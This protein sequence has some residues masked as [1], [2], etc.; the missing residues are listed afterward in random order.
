MESS[1]K[2]D[3]VCRYGGEEFAIILPRATKKDAL[4]IAE[5]IRA[6]IEQQTFQP[7]ADQALQKITVSMGISSFPE[8]GNNKSDII[9]EADEALYCAKREGRNRA[10][11]ANS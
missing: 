9:R 5:R 10:C 7:S 11:C 1:R 6:N 2:I 3:W 8:D 4:F